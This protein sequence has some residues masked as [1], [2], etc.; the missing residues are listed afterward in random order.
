MSKEKGALIGG[1]FA[2]AI[3]AIYKL[4]QISPALAFFMFIAA[5]G[6]AWGFVENK[7][8]PGNQS[9]PTACPSCGSA[10]IQIVNETHTKGRGCLGSLIHFMIF[11]FVW[12]IWIFV[13][14]FGGRKT[15]NKTKAICLNC[16]NQWYI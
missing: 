8:S 1:A 2:F 13:W 15:I 9:S 6:I 4:I 12:W 3:I 10:N 11:L 7:I 5:A 14:L 16:N